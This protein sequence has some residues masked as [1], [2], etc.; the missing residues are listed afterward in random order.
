MYNYLYD[1]QSHSDT[2][3]SYL[4]KLGMDDESIEALQRDADEHEKMQYQRFI[5]ERNQFLNESDW[6]VLRHKDQL[7]LGITTTLT[8]SAYLATLQWRQQLRDMPETY[9]TALHKVDERLTW[10]P[11]PPELAGDFPDYPPDI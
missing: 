9:T 4:K 7:A 2:T 3:P 10:P 5:E 8:E 6:T 1:G 11:I